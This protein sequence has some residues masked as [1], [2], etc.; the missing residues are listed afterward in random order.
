MEK[1]KVDRKDVKGRGSK[2]SYA[3]GKKE[4][5]EGTGKGEEEWRGCKRKRVGGKGEG[6]EG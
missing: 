3:R 5:Y 4:Q 1:G 6:H 2:Q